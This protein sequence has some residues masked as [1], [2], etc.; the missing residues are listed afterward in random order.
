MRSAQI[1]IFQTFRV[2]AAPGRLAVLMLL[3]EQA[4]T[5]SQVASR[6]S[7]LHETAAADMYYLLRL[8]LIER[9][10]Q[11]RGREPFYQLPRTVQ[12]LPDKLVIDASGLEI[13]IARS[14]KETS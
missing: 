2:L 8:G 9:S 1:D 5:I 13:T 10:F 11:K 12:A 7:T 6:L 3:A 4:Q 14:L